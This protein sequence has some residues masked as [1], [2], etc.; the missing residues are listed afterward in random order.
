MNAY[1]FNLTKEERE[2]ILDK[3]KNVYDGYVT[4][5]VNSNQQPLYVQDF[6]NDKDGITVSNKGVVKTYR[7]VGINEDIMSG[8]EFEPKKKIE[9]SQKREEDYSKGLDMIGDGPDDLKHGTID[10]ESLDIND[11][12]KDI[13]FREKYKN[14]IDDEPFGD[15]E[16]ESEEEISDDELYNECPE[17]GGLGYYESDSD[18]SE[19]GHEDC[20]LCGG[21]GE[22][23]QIDPNLLEGLDEEEIEPLRES[24]NKSLNMFKR[25]KN[26]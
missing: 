20:Y 11:T 6:A 14:S 17:C 2:N 3:H 22:Y 4:R 19:Y 18:D 15:F 25:F 1:F 8:S 12:E 16:D 26:Y 5:Y 24:V 10:D 23:S 13:F 9:S 21:T 7:N